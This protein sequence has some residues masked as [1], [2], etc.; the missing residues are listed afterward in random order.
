MFISYSY[1]EILTILPMLPDSNLQSNISA[2][3]SNERGT[4]LI[5]PDVIIWSEIKRILK[6]KW[7]NDNQAYICLIQNTQAIKEQNHMNIW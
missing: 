2:G 6:L 3:V 1:S 5:L 7:S 4:A